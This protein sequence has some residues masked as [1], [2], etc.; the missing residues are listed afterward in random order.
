MICSKCKSAKASMKRPK[1]GEI[2]CKDCFLQIF[3]DEI[4]ETI[5][6]NNLFKSGESV[7]IGASGGKDST[8]LADVL[9]LL[10]KKH[11]YGIFLKIIITIT[12]GNVVFR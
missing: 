3:E 5:I 9:M 8:V 12:I 1:N 11:N 2:L 7:A 6:N 4:H 10:N